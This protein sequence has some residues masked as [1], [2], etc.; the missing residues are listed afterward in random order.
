M[1]VFEDTYSVSI[2]S[3][4]ANTRRDLKFLLQMRGSFFDVV[5]RAAGVALVTN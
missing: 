2:R 5:R 4:Y 3:Y 1:L